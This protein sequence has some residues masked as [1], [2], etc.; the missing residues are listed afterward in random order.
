MQKKSIMWVMM[1]GALMAVT[2]TSVYAAEQAAPQKD[3]KMCLACHKAEPGQMWVEFDSVSMKSQ[4]IQLKIDARSEV[5]RFDRNTLKVVNGAVPGDLE[6]SLRAVKKG[7]QVRV[8]F[9]EKDGVKNISLLSIKPPLKVPAEKLLKTTDIEKLIALGPEKGN[10]L[11]VDSRPAPKFMEGAIPTAINIPFPSFNQM[12]DRLPRDKNTLLVFYCAGVTCALSP[13]SAKSA[14][15]LGYTNVKVYLDGTPEWTKKNYTVISPQGLKDGWMDKDLAYILLDVRPAQ[16][17]GWGFIKGAVSVPAASLAS[18][19][20]SFP[21][22]EL[23]PPVIIYDDKGVATSAKAARELTAAGY[24]NA[25]VLTGGFAAW[26]QAGLPVETGNVAT[27]VSYVP[28][29]K[30]GTITPD[31]FKKIAS[32]PLT[33]A[34]IVDVRPADEYKEGTIKGAINIPTLEMSQRLKELPKAKLI[35]L[36]CNTGTLAEMAYTILKERG[37]NA[38]YLDAKVTV[39]PDG[40]FELE[41]I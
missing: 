27:T 11:L 9:V 31:E 13:N 5:V 4:S 39:N 38:K 20:K 35:I 41:G 33:D 3:A 6:Q 19:L 24:T 32:S 8:A 30:P 26:K 15:A 25:K 1:A 34:V 23:K 18:A 17:A 16:E 28:K 36:E 10:Y 21:A 29:P 14:E 7:H 22:R 12:T 40:T 2:G 37:Y